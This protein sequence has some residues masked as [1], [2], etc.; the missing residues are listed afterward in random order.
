MIDD[1]WE[2]E[3][4]SGQ[5]GCFCTDGEYSEFYFDGEGTELDRQALNIEKHKRME[6]LGCWHCSYLDDL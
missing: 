3:D 5:E 4:K 2:W 6:E 1:E